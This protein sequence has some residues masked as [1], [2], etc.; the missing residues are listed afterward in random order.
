M[1]TFKMGKDHCP[2]CKKLVDA[3]TSLDPAKVPAPGAITICL[4]CVALLYFADDMALVKLPNKVF[5]EFD[6]E[7]RKNTLEAQRMIINSK[8]Q[9]N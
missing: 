8:L 7:T 2:V 4:Y 5:M 1:S 9:L 3:C 6:Y